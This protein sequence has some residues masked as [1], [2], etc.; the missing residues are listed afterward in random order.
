[1]LMLILREIKNNKGSKKRH[2]GFSLLE[3]IIVLI[4]TAIILSTVII[5]VSGGILNMSADRV[6]GELALAIYEAKEQATIGSVDVSKRTFNLNQALVGSRN[7][8]TITTTPIAGSNNCKGGCSDDDNKI[9]QI[10]SICVSGNS[11]CF[12]PSESFT[13]ERFSG[14]LTES[15]AIF[16]NSK[17]RTMTILITQDGNYYVA[18]LIN[19]NWQTRRDLQKLFPKQDIKQETKQGDK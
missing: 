4:I 7:G 19:N 8:V 11:F 18:E 12:T 15:H 14:R 3:L 2:N 6:V 5:K 16:I 17:K 9:G 13:F 1:M 10:T